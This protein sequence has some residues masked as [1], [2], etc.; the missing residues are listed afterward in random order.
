MPWSNDT[1]KLGLELT[2]SNP[3]SSHMKMILKVMACLQQH[4]IMLRT[5]E[6]KSLYSKQHRVQITTVP[7]VVETSSL[8][9]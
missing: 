4:R 9:N 1:T 2:L 8:P 3:D 6:L 7:R 5:M